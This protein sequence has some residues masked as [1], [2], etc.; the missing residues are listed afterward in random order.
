MKS[1]LQNSIVSVLLLLGLSLTTISA[2]QADKKS[3]ELLDALIKLNGGYEHL[4]SKKDVEFTYVYEVLGKGK[5][6]SLERYIFNGEHSWAK[7]EQHER[8]VLP[9]HKGIAIQSSVNGVSKITLDGKE[10][11]DPNEV[12]WTIFLRKV[13]F[14]WFSMMHKLMDPGTVYKYLGTEKVN[15]ITYDK[16]SLKYESSVTKKK[17]ND[18]FILYFNPKTHLI[19]EFYFTIAEFGF[20]KPEM[21]MTVTYNKL[22]GLY[23][24]TERKSYHENGKVKGI[25][26]FKDIKFNN[27][28]KAENFK[29]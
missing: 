8:H 21:R 2:Q 14:Y 26:T 1:T 28:F 27:G 17:Y 6:V 29:I 18:E 16:V 11:K 4:A 23:I 22:D 19:D 15:G 9:K 3:Q 20:T 5:D 7:Y 13:N 10:I 25:Y 24:P 12:K